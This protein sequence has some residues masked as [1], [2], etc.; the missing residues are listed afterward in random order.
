MTE[1]EQGPRTWT[2]QTGQSGPKLTFLAG[3]PFFLFP[4][5]NAADAHDSK[6]VSW[7]GSGL[8]RVQQ[9]HA[10]NNKA[11]MGVPT[12]LHGWAVVSCAADN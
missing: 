3:R 10:S 1:G 12:G 5:R 2:M 7:Q 8:Q 9:R 4:P 6:A 11:S